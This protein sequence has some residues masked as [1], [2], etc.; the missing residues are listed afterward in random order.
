[1]SFFKSLTLTFAMYSKIP[2]PMIEWDK[3][4]MEWV[5]TCF[6]LV[7]VVI[8]GALWLWLTLA[9][10]LNLGSSL[11]AVV[12]LLIPIALSGGIHL[13]GLCDTCDALGSHQS[14]ERKLEIMKD[15]HIGAFGVIGCVLYLLTLFAVWGEM[16]LSGETL[17]LLAGVPVVSRS[18]VSLAAVTR[19]NARGSGMLA[20]FTNAANRRWNQMFAGLW[21]AAGLIAFCMWSTVGCWMAAA[22]A[23]VALYAYWV[24]EKEF[25]GLTGDLA[26]WYLQLLELGMLLAA[27]IAGKGTF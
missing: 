23:L 15:S 7:G 9:H 8:G 22:S 21:L 10:W 20:T 11:T 2:M 14:R 1:M 6:P 18:W 17:V 27:A 19:K 4:S 16:T 24:T 13:D 25:G 3:K 26:G 12:A 5:F